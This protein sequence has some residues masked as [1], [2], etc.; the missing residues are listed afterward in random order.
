M[1]KSLMIF[2]F[3]FVSNLV[4]FSEEVDIVYVCR[5][6]S[7]FIGKIDKNEKAFVFFASE[8]CKYNNV[9]TVKGLNQLVEVGLS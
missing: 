8:D 1:K 6:G 4:C 3:L 9:V 7:E 5:D 2:L